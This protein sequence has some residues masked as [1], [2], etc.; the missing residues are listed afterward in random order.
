MAQAEIET[1]SFHL[2]TLIDRSLNSVYLLNKDK[3][4]IANKTLL[5]LFSF[6]AKHLEQKKKALT[7]A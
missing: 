4:A 7:T 3:R 2:Q 6:K 5:I 1:S